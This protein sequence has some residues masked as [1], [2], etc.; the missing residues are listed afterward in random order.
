[1]NSTGTKLLLLVFEG[2]IISKAS[3]GAEDQRL[4]CFSVIS[5]ERDVIV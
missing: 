1:M 3:A 2:Y 4:E 5:L